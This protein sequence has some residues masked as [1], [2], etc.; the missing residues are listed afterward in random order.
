IDLVLH[1]GLPGQ[2]YNVGTSEHR[3][4]IALTRLILQH[5]GKPESLIQHVQDRPGH[6]RRYAVDAGK[7]RALGWRPERSFEEA[8]AETVDWY[9][10]H[11]KWWRPLKSGEFLEYYRQQY[12]GR[13]RG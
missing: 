11:P 5:L 13:V 4:N 10:D 12:G 8:L 9:R 3:Q 1:V 2:V 6:D 7:L